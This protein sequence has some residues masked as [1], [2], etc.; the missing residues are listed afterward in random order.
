MT[1]CHEAGEEAAVALLT[2]QQVPP[3]IAVHLQ[4]C[5]ACRLEWE[6]LSTLPELLTVARDA[7]PSRQPQPGPALLERLLAQAARSR[8]RR[9]IAVAAAAAAGVVALA[10]P[11][12]VWLDAHRS[13]SAGPGSSTGGVAGSSTG[14][15]GR[16]SSAVL[17][18]G[19]A[20]TQTS[21]VRAAVEI[22]ATA[23]GSDVA[24][25]A[26]GL[27][28]GTVCQIVV[29]DRNG[30]SERAGSWTVSAEYHPGTAVHETVHTAPEQISWVQLIDETS[31]NRLLAVPIA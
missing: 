15:S 17:A 3:R 18:A 29:V 12:A 26:G 7:E 21:G 10:A 14:A 2:R 31:G 30:H 1:T 20:T 24:V 25:S 19:S 6:R 4:E 23:W 9:R 5:P 27:A 13:A 8:R 28:P 11:T 16:P 22:R